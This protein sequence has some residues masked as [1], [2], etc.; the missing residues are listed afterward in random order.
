V[1][2]AEYC[3]SLW[4]SSVCVKVQLRE[5]ICFCNWELGEKLMFWKF[6]VDD[7]SRSFVRS[8]FVRRSSSFANSLR[9]VVHSSLFIVHCS[10]IVIVRRRGNVC[11]RQ[12]G[13]L[14]GRGDKLVTAKV[15]GE[16]RF[17]FQS[18]EWKYANCYC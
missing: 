6:Q 15:N 7:R 16:R 5:G 12:V 3:I 14:C 9:V 2:I 10:F 18:K 11:V 17:R 1:V 13:V 8:S 4:I